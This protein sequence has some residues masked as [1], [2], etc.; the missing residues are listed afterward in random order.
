MAAYAFIAITF[1]S[2]IICLKKFYITK[3]R[4][5]IITLCAKK[6]KIGH[7]ARLGENDHLFLFNGSSI[8]GHLERARYF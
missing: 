4:S 5:K 6:K 7:H 1:I 2:N 3:R 8:A